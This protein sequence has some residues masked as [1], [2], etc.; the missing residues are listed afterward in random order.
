[1]ISLARRRM[2]VDEDRGARAC[3]LVPMRFAQIQPLSM[4][5]MTDVDRVCKLLFPLKKARVLL[6]VVQGIFRG[7][8]FAT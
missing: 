3:G 2:T 6:A 8:A 4:G 7:F 1:M 5:E